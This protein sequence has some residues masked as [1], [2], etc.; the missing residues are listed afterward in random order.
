MHREYVSDAVDA[1][2]ERMVTEDPDGASAC[3]FTS[4]AFNMSRNDQKSVAAV[5]AIAEN[6]ESV[7]TLDFLSFLLK[8]DTV[9]ALVKG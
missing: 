2:Y 6:L 3:A 4:T 9:K 8:H 7:E 1:I 5:M